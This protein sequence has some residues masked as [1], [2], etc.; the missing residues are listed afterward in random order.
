MLREIALPKVAVSKPA[1]RRI[2]KG[3]FLLMLAAM[4]VTYAAT[5]SQSAATVQPEPL[6]DFIYS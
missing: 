6:P 4:I 3:A 2:A 1:L 5:A